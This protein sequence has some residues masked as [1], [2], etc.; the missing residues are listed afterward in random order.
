[1]SCYHPLKAFLIG[2]HPSGKNKYKICSYDVD[3]VERINGTWYSVPTSFRS[4]ICDAVVRDFTEIPCGKCTGCRLEYSRQWADRCMLEL[5]YHDSAYFV[6][7]TYDDMHVPTNY[8]ADPETGESNAVY[9]LKPRDL[10]LF[11]K[12]LRKRFPDDD[13]RFFACGEYGDNT[14]RPHY[15]VIL[16]GLHLNDLRFYKRSDLNH[17]YY[18]SDSLQLCWSVRDDN[19]VVHPIGHAVVAQVTWESCA[20][21]AR[22]VMKKLNGPMSE[23]Y[24]T[25]NLEPEFTRMSR[26]P[27]IGHQYFVDHPDCVKNGH[28][29]ISTDSGGREIHPP[30]YYDRLFDLDDHETMA[31]IKQQR[32]QRAI[33][34]KNIVMSNTSLSY[35]D[36]LSVCE[37][38]LKSRIARLK[39]KEC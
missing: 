3:H 17:I 13:I 4:S 23:F 39:R 16:F 9:T 5:E 8:Y 25:F 10:Q 14:Q 1:M 20:Y 18:N 19:G 33:D 34:K 11:M 35:T 38:N 28:I 29:H 37:N 24:D 26:K 7:L 21:T 12:R 15:H 27:G 36:Y 22:Y 6:T 31:E 32:Q 2:K 30:R